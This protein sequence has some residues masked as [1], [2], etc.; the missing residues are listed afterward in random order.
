MLSMSVIRLLAKLFRNY[1]LATVYVSLWFDTSYAGSMII[2]S[3]ARNV[4]S[5]SELPPLLSA[6]A[7]G[8]ERFFAV[9]KMRGTA[10]STG[11]ECT[12]TL[13]ASNA[14]P[15]SDQPALIITADHCARDAS[16]I[17]SNDVVIDMPVSPNYFFIPAYFYDNVRDHYRYSINRIVYSSMKGA[18]IGLLQLD[19]TYG[20]L[21]SRGIKPAVLKN[22]ETS[23]VDIDLVHIPEG[24]FPDH[25][26]RHSICSSQPPVAVFESDFPIRPELPWFWPKARA[27]DCIGVSG[28]SSGSP[29]FTKGSNRVIGVLSTTTAAE[30]SGCGYARPC[31]ITGSGLISRPEGVYTNAVD[32]ILAALRADNTLDLSKLDPGTGVR[33]LRTGSWS[34]RS[35]VLESDG[36]LRP[37]KWNLR[38]EDSY[39]FVRYKTGAASSIQCERSE[40][41]GEAVKVVNQPLTGLAVDNSEGVQAIC[42]IGKRYGQPDWPSPHYATVQLRQIDNTAPVQ[43]PKI[44]TFDSGTEW[45]VGTSVRLNENIKSYFKY[46]VLDATDCHSQSGYSLFS[47][48]MTI[49]KTHNVRYCTFATDEAGNPSP[50]VSADLFIK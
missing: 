7:T 49:T 18:D 25:Y 28:G 19:V 1:L 39:E 12:A 20:E 22:F 43:V 37:A 45:Q 29:V 13:V 34:T 16:M 24:F 4:L 50:I 47:Q 15:K 36:Q 21:R 3:T 31:E 6:T 5:S 8:S 23:D 44:S 14:T 30:Y 42:V 38:I 41:Y 33:L 35:E 26:L 9:G 40:G 10:G 2:S 46:G 27:N 32:G 48:E 17:G 11:W